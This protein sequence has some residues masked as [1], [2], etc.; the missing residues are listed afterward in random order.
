[1]FGSSSTRA[2]LAVLLAVFEVAGT[3][4]LLT[5]K[6][7]VLAVCIGIGMGYSLL[8]F[9]ASG[10]EFGKWF[11]IVFSFAVGAIFFE[12]WNTGLP[13]DWLFAFVP[14]VVNATIINTFK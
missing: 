3:I 9:A 1:M 7:I 6:G 11:C 4:H 13:Q 2:V 8:A 10:N 14:P 5:P 12:P